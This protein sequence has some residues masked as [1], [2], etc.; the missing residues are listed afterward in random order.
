MKFK[1]KKQDEGGWSKLNDAL[2]PLF[3]EDRIKKIKQGK[4]MAEK[5]KSG[6]KGGFMSLLSSSFI[7]NSGD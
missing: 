2:L 1:Q 7:N 6:L 4:L 3:D 5:L